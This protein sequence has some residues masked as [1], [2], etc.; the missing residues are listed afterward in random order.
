MTLIALG[1]TSFLDR[2]FIWIWHPPDSL[3]V[4]IYLCNFVSLATGLGLLWRRTAALAARVLLAYLLLWLLVFGTYDI[5]SAPKEFGAWDGVAELAVI[6]AA[7]WVLDDGARIARVLYGISLL[8]F[9]LAHFLYL[10]RTV[11]MVPDWLPAHF[12]LACF[13]GGAFI[14]AGVAIVVGVWARLAAGLS[15]LEIGLVTVL[16]WIP[17]MRARPLEAF[18]WTEVGVSVVLTAS[19]WVVAESYRSEPWSAVRPQS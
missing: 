18:E 4:L 10:D 11:S 5:A 7:A 17:L 9:G 14:A 12:F 2:D 8:P 13:T 6:V 19:A 16:V 1:V 15:A 3:R